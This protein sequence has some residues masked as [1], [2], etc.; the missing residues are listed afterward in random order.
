MSLSLAPFL[1]DISIKRTSVCCPD[2]VSDRSSS[3]VLT[4]LGIPPGRLGVEVSCRY[5]K[6]S[7]VN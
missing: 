1:H 7:Q 4:F 5:R 3:R 2:G 6:A